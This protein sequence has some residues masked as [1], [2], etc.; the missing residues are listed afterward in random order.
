MQEILK[1]LGIRSRLVNLFSEN[2]GSH[3]FLEVLNPNTN[4]WILEDPDYNIS[5]KFK[6]LPPE[7]IDHTYGFSLI[8]FKK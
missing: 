5:Y 8:I 6:A 7:T 1:V 2:S 3:S 4:Q